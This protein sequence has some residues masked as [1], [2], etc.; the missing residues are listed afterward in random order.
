MYLIICNVGP[1]FLNG[2]FAWVKVVG[3]DDDKDSDEHH[4]HHEQ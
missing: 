1:H 2:M 3:D 4:H